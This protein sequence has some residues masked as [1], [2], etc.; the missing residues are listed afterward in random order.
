MRGET[1]K[2]PW[3]AGGT[4][5][6]MAAKSSSTPDR[7][8]QKRFTGAQNHRVDLWLTLELDRAEYKPEFQGTVVHSL[9]HP[10]PQP[11]DSP[12]QT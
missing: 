8:V 2:K 11:G 7:W 9:L 5:K 3:R 6:W 10:L 1:P 4:E 12:L